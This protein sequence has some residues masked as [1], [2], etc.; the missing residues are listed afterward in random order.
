M[1]KILVTTI[2]I[3]LMLS[4]IVNVSA[5][6]PET[7]EKMGFFAKLKYNLESGDLFTSWGEAN[8]C[9]TYPDE[10]FWIPGDNERI[11]CD[12]Y[13]SYDKCALDV[14]FDN[15]DALS[16][17]PDWNDWYGESSGE[18]ASFLP[19]SQ[20]ATYFIQVYCCPE[21]ADIGDWSTRAYVCENGEWDSKSRYD[22]DEYCGWD[23]SGVDLCWCNDE[24]ENFYVDESGNIHCTESPS[25]SWCYID[26]GTDDCI[27][28]GN[29]CF[30]NDDCCPGLDC[31]YFQCVATGTCSNGEDK[32]EGEIYYLCQDS[33]WKSQG[34]VDGNCGYISCGVTGDSCSNNDDCCEPL[35]CD[36]G[37]CGIENGDGI[38][39]CVVEGD[40]CFFDSSCCSGLTCSILTCVKEDDGADDGNGDGE[41]SNI[42]TTTWTDFYSMS[43][44]KFYNR[45]KYCLSNSDCPTKEGYDVSCLGIGEKFTEFAEREIDIFEKKCDEGFGFID[46]IL[47]IFKDIVPGF[48]SLPDLCDGLGEGWIGLKRSYK[49]GGDSYVGYCVAESNTWYGGLWEK[50]LRLVGGFGLPAQYVMIITLL[51]LITIVGVIIRTVT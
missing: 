46:E 8:D 6:S 34:R 44:D 51:L 41:V 16:G 42:I 40:R 39:E 19:P 2:A 15:D 4:L 31:Q 12:D 1:K 28:E 49:A 14:W 37:T 24:D 32:C 22:S 50:A 43:D 45:N 5:I 21:T 47:N 33:T 30:L 10:E 18:G 36:G 38:D 3:I 48:A 11:H 25:D 20:F 9:S 35:I 7:Y 17:E 27:E 13:C 29:S 23:T 26:D